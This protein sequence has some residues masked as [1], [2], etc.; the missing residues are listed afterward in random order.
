MIKPA[1]LARLD[2][3]RERLEE[4]AQLLA[5]PEV[6]AD[7]TQFRKLGQEHHELAPIIDCF[8]RYQQAQQDVES[9]RSMLSDP[10]PDMKELFKAVRVGTP[11]TIKP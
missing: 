10:D 4:V 5:D 3:L 11:V 1:L 2:N 8:E 7:Q 9:A 6:M